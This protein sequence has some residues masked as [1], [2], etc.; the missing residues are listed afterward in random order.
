VAILNSIKFIHFI[1]ESEWLLFSAACCDK[2][3]LNIQQIYQP[4]GAGV[5]NFLVT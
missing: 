3:D 1:F 4:L 5:I 2:I